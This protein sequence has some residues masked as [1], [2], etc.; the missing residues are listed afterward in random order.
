MELIDV[1]KLL[2]CIARLLHMGQGEMGSGPMSIK[3]Y[4]IFKNLI[5]Y[6]C[7]ELERLDLPLSL[8]SAHDV[9][10]VIYNGP[11]VLSEES[12]VFSATSTSHYQR[13]FEDL[14]FRFKDEVSAKKVIVLPSS[15]DKFYDSDR[16]IWG[17][18][19]EDKFLDMV[20]DI[21][22]ANNCYA[23]N[24][25]TACVFHLMRVMEKAVQKLGSKLGLSMISVCDETWDKI[26]RESR[27]Q[28]NLLYPKHADQNRIKYEAILA[29]LE[30]VKIAWRNPTMHPKATYTEEEAKALMSA[31]E[32]FIKDLVKLF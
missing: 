13:Y 15:R 1:G 11:T 21:T 17:K 14:F 16:P 20:E 31:V 8:V 12:I 24:R 30:T 10:N 26:V 22:E 18:E 19:V 4:Q 29:H 6:V 3:N 28:L 23:L 25:N 7:N 27:K 5:D 2:N 9:R 32:I